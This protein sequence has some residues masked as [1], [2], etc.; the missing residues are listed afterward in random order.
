MQKLSISFM[1][2]G[3]SFG[4]TLNPVTDDSRALF[5]SFLSCFGAVE[6]GC[7]K[8][9][10]QQKATPEM[11]NKIST[12]VNFHSASFPVLNKIKSKLSKIPDDQ[13]FLVLQNIPLDARERLRLELYISSLNSADNE[14][15]AKSWFENEV[16]IFQSFAGD[17]L[18]DYNFH[19]PRTD[20]R[21]IIGHAKKSMRRCRFCG[22]TLDSGASFKKVAHAIPEALGNKNIILADEC[23]ECN[24]FFGNN[25]E[26]NLIEY[27]DIYRVFLD[28]KGKDGT[29]EINYNNGKLLQRDGMMVV[30][31]ENVEG[32]PEHGFKVHLES[33]KTVKPI[34]LYKALCKITLSTLEEKTARNLQKTIRWLRY[35]ENSDANVAK[36]A[37]NVVHGGFSKLPKI[38][39]YIRRNNKI[40]L[41]HIVSEFRIGSFIYVYILPFSEEDELSFTQDSEFKNYWSAFPQY[42]SISGWR[43][44]DFSEKHEVKI[45]ET[46]T[47]VKTN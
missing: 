13:F 25:I 11:K 20:R 18:D 38:T 47:M 35:E 22:G 12:F 31:A 23:D 28:V 24:E 4:L 14:N 9:R 39:N 15:D 32:E 17:F 19:Q 21:T 8:I 45:N 26:P 44:S 5:I 16:K 36:V 1:T 2:D 41:P 43:F 40:H 33:S 30:I 34:S 7:L 42:K 37:M 27:L 29:P 6:D 46:I 3:D 10:A